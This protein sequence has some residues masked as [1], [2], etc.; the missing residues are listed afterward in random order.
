MSE[1]P[2]RHIQRLAS[3]GMDPQSPPAVRLSANIVNGWLEDVGAELD[4][5]PVPRAVMSALSHLP[6]CSEDL[7]GAEL[8]AQV[9]KALGC[10][11]EDADDSEDDEDQETDGDEVP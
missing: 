4:P 10:A 5:V 8:Y 6:T 2:Y 3:N 9:Q 11:D 7:L 1:I